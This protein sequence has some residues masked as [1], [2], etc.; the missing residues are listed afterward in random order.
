MKL[1][2]VLLFIKTSKMK[3][4]RKKIKSRKLFKIQ[5]NN[6]IKLM[7]VKMYQ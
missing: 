6:L 3:I 4:M 2:V 5:I 7:I 1:M